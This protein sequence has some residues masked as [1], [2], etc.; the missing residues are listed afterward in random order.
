ME[1]FCGWAHLARCNRYQAQS[2]PISRTQQAGFIEYAPFLG[3]SALPHPSVRCRP[4]RHGEAGPAMTQASPLVR[5]DVS[6]IQNEST[7]FRESPEGLRDG[8]R[9]C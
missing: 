3:L 2:G 8:Q 4:F 9:R 7:G 1:M 5:F 6:W